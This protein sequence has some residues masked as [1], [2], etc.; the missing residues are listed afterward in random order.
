MKR[1]I[2]VV[3]DVDA[4]SP[5]GRFV[6]AASILDPLSASA[7]TALRREVKARNHED[8][9][10]YLCG[11]CHRPVYLS[12]QGTYPTP[13][14]DGRE[15]FFSH[16]AD[17]ASMC[18]WG[19]G[20]KN[21]DNIDADKFQG[22]AEGERHK[23]LKK[24]LAEMLV[25]DPSFSGVSVEKVVSRAGR[26][27]KP[28]VSAELAGRLVAF[29]VQLATTQIGAIERRESFYEEN[30]IRYMWLVDA[31]DVPKLG[32]QAFQDI[33][34]NNYGQVFGL[35]EEAHEVSIK[36]GV[37]HLRVL[38]VAPR[39]TA[40][41]IEWAWGAR[42]VPHT[43]MDWNTPSGRPRHPPSDPVALFLERVSPAFDGART[44]LLGA[45][46]NRK[47]ELRVETEINWDHIAQ[48]VGVPLW[49]QAFEDQA[50]KAVGV[51]STAC[52][53]RKMDASR[54]S[55]SNLVAIF[56]EFLQ[57]E[58][59]RGW[60]VAL[61]QIADSYGHAGLLSRDTT[62]AKLHTAR[63]GNHADMAR[64]YAAMLDV[65]FPKSLM[66]RRQTPSATA[67]PLDP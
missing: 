39:L 40:K 38:A 61:E 9:S 32:H 21:P 10:R 27:C 16:H 13:E 60:A 34:W 52:E 22:A 57:H 31:L 23:R 62:Q 25:A 29:D 42:L 5:E 58:A 35:D 6:S 3:E 4:G 37:A 41:G 53:A 18:E 47:Y 65:L 63:G 28:D 8:R 7:L 20:G 48:R 24:V 12:M 14:R 33:Y 36:A 55:A 17:E 26:W 49:A 66:K 51:L 2:K 59:C 1:D 11:L 19:A 46:Q 54:Y 64:R 45:V 50:F 67:F 56:N 30:G 43:A 15:A 44:W